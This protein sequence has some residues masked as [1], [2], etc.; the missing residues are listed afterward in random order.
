MKTYTVTR[1]TPDG[2]TK[3]HQFAD[4]RDAGRQV[5]FVLHY[6]TGIS[7][8]QA[9]R[10]GMTAERERCLTIEGYTFTITEQGV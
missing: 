4:I 10:H 3:S 6:N 8:Q 9:T 7:R 5:A 1:T 2:E